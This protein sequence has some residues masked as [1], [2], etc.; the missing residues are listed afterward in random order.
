[1]SSDTAPNDDDLLHPYDKSLARYVRIGYLF[2]AGETLPA[3]AD[4]EVSAVSQS[5]T[6]MLV[7]DDILDDSASRAGKPALHVSQGIKAAIVEAMLLHAAAVDGIR[8]AAERLGT[9]DWARAR[10]YLRFNDYLS[11]MYH[12]QSLDLA[13]RDDHGFEPWML[14]RYEK[15][16]AGVTASHV[17]T[18]LECGQL[19]AGAEPNPDL[20]RAGSAIGMV[21]QV[22][23]D[24]DDYFDDHHE[25]FGDFTGGL[26]R[27]PELVFKR[28]HGDRE[29]VLELLAAGMTREARD[30]VLTYEA[31]QEI[32][33][34]CQSIRTA[35]PVGEAASFLQPLESDLTGILTRTR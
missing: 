20:T 28:H 21:R 3:E 33:G 1:M 11:E 2:A 27:L 13:A 17:T 18:G 14:E 26:N 15:I 31:R 32:Y 4:D 8:R 7:I 5:D 23:D 29:K 6:S 9:P 22:R 12:A 19:L 10:I 35:V 25:P 16:I 24:V 30:L 34:Y